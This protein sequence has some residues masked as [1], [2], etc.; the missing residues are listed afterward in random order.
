MKKIPTHTAVW[1]FVLA[2]CLLWFVAC[3]TNKT[4]VPTETFFY[5]RSF[6]PHYIIYTAPEADSIIELKDFQAGKN[7]IGPT[8]PSRLGP[9]GSLE[10]PICV[11]LDALEL[12][13][14]GDDLTNADSLLERIELVVDG[15]VYSQPERVEMLLGVETI[16]FP[17]ER[18][19]ALVG[20]PFF[21][22]WQ[23][24]LDVGTHIVQLN[25]NKSGEVLE[26]K[27]S[28]TLMEVDR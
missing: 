7:Y 25:V 13:S 27:W 17:E 6:L 5:E 23:S 10:Q 20:G 26:Y 18:G 4:S 21:L 24:D 15:Q 3:G 16:V 9:V 28:F 8:G 1:L 12:A 22:C 19:S 11:G 2:G 14:P